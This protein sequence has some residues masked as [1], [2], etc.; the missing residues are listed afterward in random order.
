MGAGGGASQEGCG[1]HRCP[2]TGPWDP[3]KAGDTSIPGGQEL[4]PR[5]RWLR[6]SE[7]PLLFPARLVA[8]QPINTQDS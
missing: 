1:E 4:G 2:Q 5:E 7:Q 3:Q 6:G 8:T